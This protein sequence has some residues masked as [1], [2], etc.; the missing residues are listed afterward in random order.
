[1]RVRRTFGF[2]DLCGFTALTEFHGDELATD[3]LAD[4]R[5]AVR[6]ICSRRAVRV[7]KWLGDGAMLVGVETEPVVVAVLEH[8]HRVSALPSHIVLRAGLTVGDVI[9]FEGDDYIGHPVNLAARLCDLAG[10]HDV[11][12]TPEIAS[13]APP[14]VVV[15]DVGEREIRG[16]GRP[17]ALVELGGHP[18]STDSHRRSR[19]ADTAS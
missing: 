2:L 16:L 11:L 4:F 12:A 10:P 3:L 9:L 18:V 8:E 1:M 6:E 5:A 7:A 13:L 14:W 17:V 15:T 19:R